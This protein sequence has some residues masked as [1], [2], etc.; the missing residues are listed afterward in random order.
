MRPLLW[1]ATNPHSVP[2]GQPY[3][4]DDPNLFFG[5]DGLGYAREPGDPGF[6]PYGPPPE[7][8]SSLTQPKRRKTMPKSDYIKNR[9]A[10]FSAQLNTFKL[11]IGPYV[12]T[13]G[14]TPEQVAAQ[15][16]DAAYFAYAL[17]CQEVCINGSQQWTAWKDL[18][19]EGGT[20]PA[21][22][23]PA[24]GVLPAAVPAVAPGVEVRFR[25]L[26][27]MIKAHPAYN[28]GI[29]QALGIEGAAQTGPDFATFKPVFAAELR[30]GQVF[31]AWTWQGQSAYLDMIELLVD[32]ADGKGFVFLAQDT[33]PGYA[34]S[35]PLPATPAKWTYKAIFRVGDQRVGQWSDEVSLTV[36]G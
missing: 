2:P 29:G 27:K 7:P 23:A 30:G 36:G 18:I 10:E 32:R 11:N 19:R 4:W 22:G 12:A 1:D 5:P 15:A 17:A 9:D 34:D 25:A 6:V 16:A 8:L 3:R 21:S 31:I 33:T 20:P 26:V 13:F 14:L 35:T 24:G 28:E